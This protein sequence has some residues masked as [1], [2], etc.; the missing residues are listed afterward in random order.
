MWWIARISLNFVARFSERQHASTLSSWLAEE[1][2]NCM[3]E[4]RRGVASEQS[5]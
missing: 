2:V 4:K 1:T 3:D 5:E